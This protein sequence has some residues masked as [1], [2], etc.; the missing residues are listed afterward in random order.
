MNS[1]EYINTRLEDQINWYSKKSQ[2]NQRS[3]KVI[4][5]IQILCASAIPY[6]SGMAVRIT[7]GNELVGLLGIVV[8]ICVGVGS[9]YRFQEK[10]FEYRLSAE[11]LEQERLFYLTA[12][13]PYN[14]EDT[15]QLLVV[16]CEDIMSAERGR[17]QK[18]AVEKEIPKMSPAPVDE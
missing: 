10:W 14:S 1:D 2:I 18:N 7:Y 6:L 16:R 9:L 5:V 8:A 3:Y 4:N 11:R 12:V 13:P 17:W 15:F